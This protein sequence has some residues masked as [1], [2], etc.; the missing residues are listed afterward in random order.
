MSNFFDETFDLMKEIGLSPNQ[1]DFIGSETGEYKC[2]WG[3]FVLL[4]D[5]SYEVN[6]LL[7]STIPSDL[8]IVFKNGTVFVRDGDDCYEY[9][10]VV[11]PT[12]SQRN[13][14]KITKLFSPL[15]GQTVKE[16]NE[17]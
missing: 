4:A 5:E 16:T 2:T 11:I 6:G 14:K 3:E 10:R 13:V 17:E 7:W 1:I 12:K 8:V 9:W 15:L